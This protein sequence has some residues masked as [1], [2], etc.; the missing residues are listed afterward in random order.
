[1]TAPQPGQPVVFRNATVLT[2]DDAHTVLS[3]A[4]VLVSGERIVAVGPGLAV[5]EGTAEIDVAVFLE[6]RNQDRPD[7]SQQLRHSA[8]ASHLN[9]AYQPRPGR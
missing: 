2:M 7:A 5:F 3:N 9:A 4:D 6:G 8:R 1:M